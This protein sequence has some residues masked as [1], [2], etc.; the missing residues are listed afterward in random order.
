MVSPS[1]ET[2][3]QDVRDTNYHYDCGAG[4]EVCKKAV[5]PAN[6]LF[7][8]DS[9]K[10]L[11][12]ILA[13]GYAISVGNNLPAEERRA[14]RLRWNRDRAESQSVWVREKYDGELK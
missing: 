11:L 7:G 10:G 4:L 3:L 2:T 9:L 6:E 13:D 8:G 12:Y 5:A 1:L 14:A